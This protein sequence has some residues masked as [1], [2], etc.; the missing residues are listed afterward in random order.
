[1]PEPVKTS[2][3]D[4][5]RQ[6]R[7]R[8][9]ASARE[10]FI[11]RGYADTTM[12]QIAAEA[13]VAVQTVYY[14][15]R[16][17]GQLLCEVVEVTAAGSDEPTPP[18]E[19]AAWMQ[20]VVAARSGQRAIA[21][22]VEHGT[23]IYERVAMLWPA[24]G[25]ATA[26]DSSVD[27]FW[28]DVTARRRAGVGRLVATV[29]QLDRLRPGLDVETATDLVG[30]L[31]GQDVFRAVTQDARWS[32]PSYQAWLF[33]TLV[34]QLLGHRDLESDVTQDLSFGGMVGGPVTRVRM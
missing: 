19:P 24:V 31:F 15:F 25:A 1:M 7:S 3:A 32:V 16:T 8:M 21:L 26:L 18:P 29:A 20:E 34:D 22:A 23:G 11:A 10:L 2:R 33:S 5:A 28:R 12:N 6:T 14:T 9:L 27:R 4:R 13:G 17:K 30:V